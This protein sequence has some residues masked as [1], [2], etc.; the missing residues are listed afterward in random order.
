M[1]KAIITLV[2]ILL[3]LIGVVVALNF[4]IFTKEYKVTEYLNS[5]VDGDYEKIM[6]MLDLEESHFINAKVLSEEFANP[7]VGIKDY[8]IKKYKKIDENTYHVDVDVEY[9]EDYEDKTNVKYTAKEKR[10]VLKK[11]KSKKYLIFDKWYIKTRKTVKNIEFKLPK[12]TKTYLNDVLVTEE[13]I[14]NKGNVDTYQIPEL[15]DKTYEIKM[16]YEFGHTQSIYWNPK[17]LGN[18]NMT[19]NLEDKEYDIIKTSENIINSMV[20]NI[21]EEKTY[22]EFVNSLNYGEYA[23]NLTDK[24]PGNFWLKGDYNET[25]EYY[26]QGYYN[27]KDLKMNNHRIYK[28]YITKGGRLQVNLVFDYENV[29]YYGTEKHVVQDKDQIKLYYVYDNGELKLQDIR[30]ENFLTIGEEF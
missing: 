13:F 5:Y 4:T 21:K 27:L 18:Y 8:K 9:D 24:A 19:L 22:E 23:T 16:E 30:N 15:F 1:K 3:L 12:N 17:S 25:L 2:I 26:K 10:I 11:A 28:V 29:Y 14:T 6:E 20:S 7:Y